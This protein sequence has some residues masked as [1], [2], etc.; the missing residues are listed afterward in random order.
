MKLPRGYTFFVLVFDRQTSELEKILPFNSKQ[1]RRAFMNG[2]AG[3]QSKFYL[4][5]EL[6]FSTVG[7]FPFDERQVG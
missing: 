5:A 7:K 1:T 6:D 2:A 4:L 3:D